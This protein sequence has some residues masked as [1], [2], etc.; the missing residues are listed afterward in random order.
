MDKSQKKFIEDKVFYKLFNFTGKYLLINGC[1]MATVILWLLLGNLFSPSIIGMVFYTIGLFFGI[2]GFVSVIR[3][4]VEEKRHFQDVSLKNYMK[5]MRQSLKQ[6]SGFIALALLAGAVVLIDIYFLVTVVGLSYFLP[7]F[8]LLF[9]LFAVTMLL[10]LIA[11][12]MKPKVSY[13]EAIKIGFLLTLKKWHMSLAIFAMMAFLV[14]AI[15]VR[16]DLGLLVL[17]SFIFLYTYKLY[18]KMVSTVSTSID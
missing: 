18:N 12:V 2:I 1:F 10:G 16:S 13:K 6:D 11:R 17:P 9:S 8:L 4:Y 7:L 14:L 5:H 3:L 15:F